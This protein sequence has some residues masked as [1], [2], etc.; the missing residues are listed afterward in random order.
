MSGYERR[1]LQLAARQ[2]AGRLQRAQLHAVCA[3]QPTR[4]RP[5]GA[6]RQPGLGL[7]H[8]A[9]LL[10]EVGGQPQPVPGAYRVPPGRRLPHRTRVAVAYAPSA[11]LSGRGPA[12]RISG[13][14]YQRRTPNRLH[15]RAGKPTP[16]LRNR[17]P[18]GPLTYR[19]R[20]WSAIFCRYV[21]LFLFAF[22]F[23]FFLL[24]VQYGANYDTETPV[25]LAAQAVRQRCMA[26]GVRSL[27]A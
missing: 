7:R 17:R 23:S 1:P 15:D 18:G 6:T 22:N 4:L 2:S 20:S 11:R 24:A 13:A 19:L 9:A 8:R 25:L 12:T 26:Q 21:P 10:Q 5:L 16:V 3:R 14:R 27:S